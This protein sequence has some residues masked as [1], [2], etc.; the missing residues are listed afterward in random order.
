MVEGA[1]G[2]HVWA[3]TFDRPIADLFEIQD[4]ITSRISAMIA[5]ELELF[6]LRKSAGQR[7]K[8]L[9]AWE[10]YVQGL[11]YFY[12]ETAEGNVQA[13]EMFERAIKRDSAY[14]EAWARLGWTYAHDIMIGA[15]V[16]RE[17][18]IAAALTAAK[19]AVELDDFSP[20]AH[21]ALSSVYVWSGDLEMGVL[22]VQRALELNPHDASAAMALGNRLDLVG[23]TQEGIARMI[24]ALELNPR[25]PRRW[26]YF[27]FLSRAYT[28]LGEYET[29]VAWAKRAVQVRPDQADAHYRL[30]LCLAHYGRADEARAALLTC[31]RISP[32]YTAKRAEWCPYPDPARNEKLF[33]GLRRTGLA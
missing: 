20:F 27:G 32:G 7:P 23:R 16:D 28:S 12:Q 18:T 29:A 11:R 8:D 10:L 22:E 25:D 3:D 19:R 4:Q 26:H 13:R 31:E 15:S 14:C 2:H 21:L 1:S 6:E 24:K 33:A 9:G 5:P 17:A 30:A